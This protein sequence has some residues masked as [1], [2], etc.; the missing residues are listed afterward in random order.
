MIGL[1]HIAYGGDYNPEQ[2]PTE[3]WDEDVVLMQRA[4]VNVATV[5][6]FSWA[7]LEPREGEFDFAWL[8]DVLDRLHAGGISVD[9][10]TAT[11]SPPPWVAHKY[12]ASLPVTVDGVTLSP[13]SR[14]HYSPSSSDYRR[15]ALRLVRKLAERYHG[16]P[17][18]VAWHVNNEYG[19][20]VSHS[21][22]DESAEAFRQWLIARYETVDGLNE[23]WGTAFWSQQ[24]SSFDEVLPPRVAPAQPNPSQ[25]LDFDRFS[26]DALL[27]LY[28]AEVEVLREV[29][30]GIPITTNFMGFFPGV[31]YWTWAPH[32]DF[33]SDDAYPDPSDPDSVIWA[34]AQRDLMRS[35]RGGQPW[36][37]MEQA[38]SAVNWRERNASKDPGANRALSMQ[39]VARGADGIL[40]FQWR[41]SRSG[42]EKF[43]SAIVPHAGPESRVFR[44]AA[45]LGER[46]S[47]LDSVIGTRV[48]A[49]VA[50]VFDWNSWWAAEQHSTPAKMSYLDALKPWYRAFYDRSVTV[51][52]V[53]PHG[54][55][56]GYDLVVA[57][58][59]HIADAATQ[60]SLDAFVSG[61]GVLAMTYFSAILDNDTSVHLDGYLGELQKTFGLRIE[62]FAPVAAAEGA[63]LGPV[64]LGGELAGGASLWRE[65]IQPSTAGVLATFDGALT[66]LPAITRNERGE[67]T[68]WYVGTQP[69]GELTETIVGRLLDEAGVRGILDVPVSGVEAVQRGDLVFVINHAGDEATVSIAGVKHVV[70]GREFLTIPVP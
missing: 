13:G 47:Q 58:M 70:A 27:E 6:V 42:A 9:L 53:H 17:A 43:H 52:F 61:G 30:P 11:A 46:L 31:D 25:V 29:S 22:D 28:R 39:S 24:Y 49:S 51:D 45:E 20:H 7:K 50:I 57:P 36:V 4:R 66:G 67:G 33:V 16:H 3:V 8:D 41:Q 38:T 18:L 48:P 62:E 60:A 64:V 63:E 12:P 35:L 19:C 68:A 69:D 54:D 55:L 10:A 2:W 37:L 14:Q 5:G 40:Y 56:S 32:V 21:Y 34:A 26:S 65:Y 15:L 59:M 1:P 23:A 44:E